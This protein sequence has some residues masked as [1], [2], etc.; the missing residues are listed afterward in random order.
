[1][2]KRLKNYQIDF[3][4]KKKERKE[5]KEKKK[6]TQ[7]LCRTIALSFSQV[8]FGEGNSDLLKCFPQLLILLPQR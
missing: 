4:K 7:N 8:T 5:K 1:M 6:K 2:V 3:L